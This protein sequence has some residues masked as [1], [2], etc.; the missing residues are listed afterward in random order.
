RV[1]EQDRGIPRLTESF[2]SPPPANKRCASAP[3]ESGPSLATK[4]Q[5]VRLVPHLVAF[6]RFPES[7]NFHRSVAGAHSSNRFVDTNANG[8][9]GS[10]PAL[11]L[12]R[13]HRQLYNLR[14]GP[15]TAKRPLTLHVTG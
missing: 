7:G 2:P 1:R 10:S 6:P 11:V 3:A 14:A 13:F 8:R 5:P 15:S 4:P 9:S 12:R